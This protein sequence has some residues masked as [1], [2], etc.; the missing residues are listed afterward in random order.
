MKNFVIISVPLGSAPEWVR[1]E[2]V[3]VIL[4]LKEQINPGQGKCE[5]DFD[6]IRQKD[7]SFVTCSTREALKKLVEK[8]PNAVVWFFDHLPEEILNGNISF[9]ADEVRIF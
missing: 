8:N 6:F 5:T 2:W 1:K 9:G 3:G 7:R 4:P